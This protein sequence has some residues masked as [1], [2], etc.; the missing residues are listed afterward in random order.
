MTAQIVEKHINAADSLNVL[1]AVERVTACRVGVPDQAAAV[2]AQR[3]LPRALQAHRPVNVKARPV[4][5][6]VEFDQTVVVHRGAGKHECGVAADS[7]HIA[8][9]NCQPADGH[10]SVETDD[11]VQRVAIV[12]QHIVD[13]AVGHSRR[14]PER[15]VAPVPGTASPNNCGL[16]GSRAH[17]GADQGTNQGEGMAGFHESEFFD[18]L[19]LIA[20]TAWLPPILRIDKPNFLS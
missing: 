8:R 10:G 18:C 15:R 12:E 4:G 7:Q 3:H 9:I 5:V 2:V 14:T 13:D 6:R 19:A 20:G 1:E 16:G 17:S 11:G